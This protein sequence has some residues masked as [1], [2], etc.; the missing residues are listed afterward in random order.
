M[1]PKQN[2]DSLTLRTGENC[3]NLVG[4]ASPYGRWPKKWENWTG[5][6]SSTE[7][8]LDS[9]TRGH[10]RS[11]ELSRDIRK[12]EQ[13]SDLAIWTAVWDLELLLILFDNEFALTMSSE[14]AQVSDFRRALHLAA[15]GVRPGAGGVSNQPPP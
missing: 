12:E 1:K 8:R 15:A 7:R 3:G 2:G 14:I 10:T 4:R 5:T 13:D 6:I 11:P 9:R